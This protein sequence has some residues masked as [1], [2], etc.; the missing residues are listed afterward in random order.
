MSFNISASTTSND[1]VRLQK[2]VELTKLLMANSVPIEEVW[3]WGKS[4]L[5][6]MLSLTY[7]GDFVSIYLAFL[8]GLDPTPIEVIQNL[9]SEMAKG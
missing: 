2:R 7:L 4:R 1:A 6:K 5:A 9:K 3:A 8:Q